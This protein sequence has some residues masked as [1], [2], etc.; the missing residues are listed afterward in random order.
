MDDLTEKL[1]VSDLDTVYNTVYLR[2]MGIRFD[3][4]AADSQDSDQGFS[5]LT[6]AWAFLQEL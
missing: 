5:F 6:A 1:G 3:E 4:E 2:A